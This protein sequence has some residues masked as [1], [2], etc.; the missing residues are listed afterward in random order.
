LLAGRLTLPRMIEQISRLGGVQIV[1]ALGNH[2]PVPRTFGYI[3]PDVIAPFHVKKIEE[4]I[5][6]TRIKAVCAAVSGV[7]C[8]AEAEISCLNPRQKVLG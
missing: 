7:C 2:L 4:G 8:R 1:A 6:E 5:E 3:S